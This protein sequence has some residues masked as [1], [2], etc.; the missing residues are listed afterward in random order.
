MKNPALV[1]IIIPTF[2][3]SL[4][5]KRAIDSCVFQSYQNIE[6]I[7]V[8]D[9]VPG[10]PERENTEYVLSLY[11]KDKR[12]KYY[13]H[14]KNKNGAAARNTGFKKSK[15]IYVAFLDDDDYFDCNKILEQVKFLNSHRNLCAATCSIY[16]NGTPVY[17][18]EKENYTFEILT[19]KMTPP[20][21]SLMIRR[22]AFEATGGFDESYV[23]HQDYEFLI[24]LFTKCKI[25]KASKAF[26]YL[27]SD[28]N[29]N[30]PN[31]KKLEEIKCK[32]VNDFVNHIALEDRKI[33]LK[34][35]HSAN[36]THLFYAYLKEL[37]L[38]NS[39]RLINTGVSKGFPYFFLDMQK[40]LLNNIMQRTFYR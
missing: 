37:D 1:S 15:G 30:R 23:R 10:S 14:K 34:K 3:S 26:V 4:T 31:A 27:C 40:Y 21:P 33:M 29:D 25:G 22:N 36:S 17:L 9:N 2:K 24:R 28:G 19:S 39:I 5:L 20:T 13:K 11:S 32:F 35:I 7:V 6:I 18:K 16:K 38:K 8:D 12:V